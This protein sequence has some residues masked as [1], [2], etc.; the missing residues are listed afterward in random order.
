MEPR[1]YM[2]CMRGHGQKIPLR[3][4]RNTLFQAKYSFFLAS[5]SDS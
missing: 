1:L 4:H 2:R 5:S 3:I